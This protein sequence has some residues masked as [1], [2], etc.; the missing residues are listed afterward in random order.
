MT[1]IS[2]VIESLPS[3]PSHPKISRTA[4]LLC[5]AYSEWLR[6]HP[7]RLFPAV[8]VLLSNV[9]D[10]GGLTLDTFVT[11]VLSNNG[12][13]GL[14]CYSYWNFAF[15]TRANT[16]I[17]YVQKHTLPNPIQVALAPSAVMAF[18][19]LC[20]ECTDI[21]APEIELLL[22][23]FFTVYQ[24][25]NIKNREKVQILCQTRDMRSFR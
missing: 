1:I 18:R 17:V 15:H 9:N 3:L 12:S 13:Q 14:T 4:L 24:N 11:A 25:S 2:T 19:D 21:M 22:E 10:V 5:G 6:N 8:K 16:F 7:E 20:I 23:P